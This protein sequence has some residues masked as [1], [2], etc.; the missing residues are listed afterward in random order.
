MTPTLTRVVIASLAPDRRISGQL[1]TMNLVIAPRAVPQAML[2]PLVHRFAHAM[3]DAPPETAR[4][5][6]SL[7]VARGSGAK[8]TTWAGAARR[9]GYEPGDGERLAR[10]VSARVRFDPATSLRTIRALAQQLDPSANYRGLEDAV[11]ARAR[12]EQWFLTWVR[13]HRPGTRPG[14]RPYAVTWLWTHAASAR[15]D[16]TPAWSSPPT[17][18]RK[19]AYRRFAASLTPDQKLTLCRVL[20]CGSTP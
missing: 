12:E 8:R 5:Y 14:S 19:A 18:V 4:A 3:I 16:T 11:R 10:A 7:C 9:L 6:L 13:C 1:D 17:L 15:L 20:D 2:A